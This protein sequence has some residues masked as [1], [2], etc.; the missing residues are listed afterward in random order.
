MLATDA[1]CVKPTE[2]PESRRIV[3]DAPALGDFSYKCITE[4]KGRRAAP[5][6]HVLQYPYG[7]G[8]ID[9]MCFDWNMVRCRSWSS[10]LRLNAA[11][12]AEPESAAC[13]AIEGVY[14]IK[15]RTVTE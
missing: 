3:A 15:T 7:P 14:L 4:E 1:V 13:T 11:Q 5:R 2:Q 9:G 6:R 8:I 12:A 10:S